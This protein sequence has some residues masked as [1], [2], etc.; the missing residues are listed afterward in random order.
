MKERTNM[1][2]EKER[3]TPEESASPIMKTLV[4]SHVRAFQ[5]ASRLTVEQMLQRIRNRFSFEEKASD[6]PPCTAKKTSPIVF[7]LNRLRSYR[8]KEGQKT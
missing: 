5:W 4:S 3:A 7:C 8:E 6:V 1:G 2:K